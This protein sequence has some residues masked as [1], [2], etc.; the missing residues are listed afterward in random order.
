MTTQALY[1]DES[2][3]AFLARQRLLV[4]APHSDDETISSGGLIWRVKEA[5]GQ[6]FVMVVSVG[7]LDHFDGDS[8]GVTP[9]K[10]RA[11]ELGDAMRVLGVDD[12]EILFQDNQMHLRMDSMPRRDLVNWVEREARLATEKTKPTMMVLPAPSFNQDHE[13]VFKAGLTACRPHLANLKAFQRVVLVADMPQLSWNDRSFHPN[14]YVDISH[15]LDKKLAAFSK[16]ISQL[17][18]S[19]HQGGLDALEMLARMRGR[20]ISVEAAE[21]YE[22]LRFVL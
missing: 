21:A 4:L 17:R 5:G 11:D 8:D 19:P 22:L 15:C 3:E 7:D 9:G 20:E 10:A 18:P 14:F 6:V 12:F 16:H 13:A 2:M 1:K